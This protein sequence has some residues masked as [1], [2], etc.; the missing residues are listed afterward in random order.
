[1]MEKHW[2]FDLIGAP[3]ADN[4]QGP[5]E[6]N[7]WGLMRWSFANFLDV[8]LP[9]IDVNL[10]EE[11]QEA[12]IRRVASVSGWR[13]VADNRPQDLDLTLMW[14][15]FGRHIGMTLKVN[16]GLC[17]FHSMEDV[18]VTLTAL[19]DLWLFAYR[20]ITNWRRYA[21]PASA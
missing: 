8:H 19:S 20:D 13:R 14:G 21:I 3:Y 2:A 1:M 16:G 5:K 17:L 7:C 18:G 9:L 4:G 12:E 15:P 6:F 11:S 10:P